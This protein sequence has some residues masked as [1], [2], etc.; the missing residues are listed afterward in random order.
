QVAQETVQDHVPLL[1]RVELAPGDLAADPPHEVPAD[2]V[3]PADLRRGLGEGGLAPAS[4]APRLERA[5]LLGGAG[6]GAG[7]VERGH[8][9]APGIVSEHAPNLTKPYDTPP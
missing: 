6:E 9:L 2:R 8:G 4:R 3:G 1:G 7:T 5:V